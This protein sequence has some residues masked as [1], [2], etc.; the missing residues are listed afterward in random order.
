MKVAE[1]HTHEPFDAI[2]T[3]SMEW[4]SNPALAP[5]VDAAARQEN[6]EIRFV[7]REA[8]CAVP[9]ALARVL[10]DAA[11]A[12]EME[13]RDPSGRAL[14][15][16]SR[17]LTPADG[18]GQRTERVAVVRIDDVVPADRHV[19]VLQLDVEGFE[20]H[21]LEGALAT[22]RRGRPV[23]V[24]ENLPPTPWMNEHV[25]SLGYSAA[26]RVDVNHVF[27]PHGATPEGSR[28]R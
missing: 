18:G 24:L 7:I 4:I 11:G 22:I 15:G 1:G 19:S 8:L 16:A 3:R 20:Q 17:L 10:P 6:C 9:P 13:V 28:T 23:L 14:G 27:E 26:G 5:L 2:A 25:H 21:A 12:I